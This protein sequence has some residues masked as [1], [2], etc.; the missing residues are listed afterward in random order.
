[1]AATGQAQTE[2]N[3]ARLTK[4]PPSKSF[5]LYSISVSGSWYRPSLDYWN[6]TF[7][8][9]S[10]SPDSFGGKLLYGGNITFKLPQNLGAR[11]GVW[12]WN[13]QVSGGPD[14]T[15]NSL[16][17]GFTG[18]SLDAFYRFP[19]PILT[20][21]PYIGIGGSYFVI[22]NKY[23]VGASMDKMSGHDV[24]LTPFIGI[25]RIFFQKLVVGL[26]AGYVMG[27][28]RQ[29]V[30]TFEGTTNPIVSVSGF[31]MG[32]SIGYKF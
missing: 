7:L 4:S 20:L 31:K 1:M 29:V 13:D 18:F 30:T 15:F 25:E 17:I 6:S 32:V 28:Y 26:E 5:G 27:R 3:S 24:M 19:K 11:V 2:N 10:G 14:A 9:A 21:S 22:Q 23:T 8:P 16:Q 12:F